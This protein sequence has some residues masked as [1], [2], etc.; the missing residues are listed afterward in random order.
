MSDS[1]NCG[2]FGRQGCQ[3]EDACVSG[4]GQKPEPATLVS[5]RQPI[6]NVPGVVVALLAAFVAVHVVRYLLPD[7]QAAWLTAVLAFIPH[8]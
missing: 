6:F 1:R 4:H 8:A 2:L 5:E 3:R 7:E